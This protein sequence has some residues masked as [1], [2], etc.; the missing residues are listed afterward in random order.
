MIAYEIV[1]RTIA[2]RLAR[3]GEIPLSFCFI[4]KMQWDT[5]PRSADTATY[6]RYYL[7]YGSHRRL[8]PFYF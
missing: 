3:G 7:G 2:W 6:R 1:Y 4:I 5:Y 8:D